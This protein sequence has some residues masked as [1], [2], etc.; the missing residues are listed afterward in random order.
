MLKI[1]ETRFQDILFI[2]GWRESKL[3]VAAIQLN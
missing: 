2:G 1:Y 3:F